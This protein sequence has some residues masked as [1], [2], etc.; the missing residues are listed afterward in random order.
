MIIMAASSLIPGTWCE[1][2]SENLQFEELRGI[3]VPPLGFDGAKVEDQY[4]LG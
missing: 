2:S 4:L 1:L 3:M